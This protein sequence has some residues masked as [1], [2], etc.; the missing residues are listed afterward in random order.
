M[1]KDASL[2]KNEKFFPYYCAVNRSFELVIYPIKPS[3]VGQFFD[4]S[5]LFEHNTVKQDI[6]DAVSRVSG[7]PSEVEKPVAKEFKISDEAIFKF[8]ISGNLPYKEIRNIADKFEEKLLKVDGVS[9]VEKNG[10]LN[11]EVKIKVD[12]EKLLKHNIALSNIILAIQSRNIRSAVGNLESYS[13]EKNIVT[14][15]QFRKPT[16]VGKVV[17]SADFEGPIVLIDDIATVEDGFEDADTI[18]RFDGKQGI[19]FAIKKKENSDVIRTVDAIKITLQDLK[20]SLPPEVS[21]VQIE[22]NSTFVRNRLQV[23]LKNGV[24]GLILVLVLL[25]LFM[26]LKSAFWVGFLIPVTLLGA[27]IFIASTVRMRNFPFF[28]I[29]KE[30]PCFPSKR[31]MVS[32]SSKPSSTVAISSI[33]TIGPSK[34]ADKT[35]FPT[36]VGLRN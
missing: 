10:Y 25:G 3:T 8:G 14:L 6:R 24:I 23:V 12:S 35:T 30:I 1:L 33:N 20:E 5:R 18:S 17:L 29:A 19:S 32:A 7:L 34:S 4:N 16:E 15:A 9:I 27:V 21:F 31:E 26:N 28:L 2:Q 22:D 36:S 11:R 13:N